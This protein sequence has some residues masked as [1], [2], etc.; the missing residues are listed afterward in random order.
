MNYMSSA[1]LPYSLA[2][3][4]LYCVSTYPSL[5]V[6]SLLLPSPLL[7][8]RPIP[9]LN[10]HAQTYRPSVVRLFEKPLVEVSG[11]FCNPNDSLTLPLHLERGKTLLK[12]CFILSVPLGKYS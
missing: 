9:T 6:P 8:T 11:L 2:P 5:C 1:S 3:L 7:L 12:A 10:S 4:R